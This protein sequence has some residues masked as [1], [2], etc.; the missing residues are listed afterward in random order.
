MK[1]YRN[2]R[3]AF[4]RARRTLKNWRWCR[5]YV[6]D[7]ASLG[8]AEARRRAV[9]QIL[10]EIYSVPL[11]TSGPSDAEVLEAFR[12]TEGS[13][14]QARRYLDVALYFDGTS[15][16]GM[17]CES[18]GQFPREAPAEFA[19]PKVHLRRVWENFE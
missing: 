2:R 13:K 4:Q 1:R 3:L 14:V 10:K 12:A 15:R 7:A 17:A 6:L 8:L 11:G 5:R 19:N 9:R 18:L 16:H